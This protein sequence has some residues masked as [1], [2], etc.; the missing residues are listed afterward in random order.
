MLDDKSPDY[1]TE[2][3][4]AQY[5]FFH[6]GVPTQQFP[7]D[8]GAADGLCFPQRC[9]NLALTYTNPLLRCRAFDLGCGVGAAT[10]TLSAHFEYVLG[11]DYSHSF[12]AAAKDLLKTRNRTIIVPGEAKLDDE[13]CIELP[14]NCQSSKISFIQGDAMS[15]P[16]QM[17]SFDLVL[18]CNLLC[19]LSHP[20]RLIEQFPNLVN[21]GG[22][23][24]I[25]TPL[26]WLDN[27][28]HPGDRIGNP[29]QT[30]IGVLSAHFTDQFELIELSDLPFLIR[31]H[32]RKYQYGIAQASVW[33]RY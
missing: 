25:T 31:E 7:F 14:N 24:L 12:I 3:L 21:Q 20:L 26:T 8:F 29:E 11:L 1:E 5:L 16:A 6:F 32:R 15:L 17:D 13:F 9:A 2:S 22:I 28:T 33:R 23:L 30:A 4:L 27:L 10:M 18:A 19:R